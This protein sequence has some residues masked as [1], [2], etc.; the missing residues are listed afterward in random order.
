[1]SL[2]Q[3]SWVFMAVYVGVMLLFGIIG[4]RRVSGADD[5]AVA[6]Q[7]YGPFVLALAFASTAASGATFLGLPGLTYSYGMSTIWLAFM[8][9]LG[10]YF[11]VLICQRTIGR[12]GNE[13]GARSIPEYLGERYQ[14]E[15][16]RISAAVFSLMLLFYLAGQLVAGLVMFEIMLG[17]PQ[18]WALGITVACTS[19]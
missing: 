19:R 10:I 4:S 14:S 2:Y 7:S 17:V 16:L 11:G 5:F 9:P 3:W 15:A 1:M 18:G 6:R 13:S 8:Y 12:F